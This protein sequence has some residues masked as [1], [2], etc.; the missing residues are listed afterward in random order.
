MAL[1][2]QIY[3]V[4]CTIALAMS[5]NTVRSQLR[6]RVRAL[7]STV[8]VVN[9][10]LSTIVVEASKKLAG[11]FWEIDQ[12]TKRRMDMILKLYE[13]GCF[14]QLTFFKNSLIII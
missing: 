4:L 5:L 3:L 2:H 8:S 1:I 12:Q 11:R 7:S 10:D 14:D 6:N 13:V 9:A